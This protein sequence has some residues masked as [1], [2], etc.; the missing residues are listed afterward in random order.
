MPEPVHRDARP[1]PLD[2]A[3]R[4]RTRDL[5]RMVERTGVMPVL[6]GGRVDRSTYCRL[7]RNLFAIYGALERALQRHAGHPHLQPLAL[8]GLARAP[9]IAEDLAVLH[10]PGWPHELPVLPA[11]QR[12]VARL[13]ELERSAPARLAAHAYVRYLGD[14]SGGRL[15]RGIVGRSLGLGVDAGM[16]F[17]DFGD[18]DQAPAMAEQF[19][20][21][22]RAIPADA[23]AAAELVRE[24]RWG[25][26]CHG[27]MFAQIL[28]APAAG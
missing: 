3:L 2:E 16:R 14:L 1:E 26:A 5:H 11:A 4:T 9:G 15:L 7:L 21:G 6:L 19:R 24:A 10:G 28:T 23:A 22:L 25:F 13:E 20:A 12:Y 17:Y 8:P 18:P 27:E